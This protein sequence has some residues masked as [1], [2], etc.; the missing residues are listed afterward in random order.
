MIECTYR[1]SSTPPPPPY[2][3]TLQRESLVALNDHPMSLYAVYMHIVF[4]STAV[5]ERY[6]ARVAG[7]AGSNSAGNMDVSLACC[8]V[9]VSATGRSLVQRSPTDCGVCKLM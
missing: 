1:Q 9:E 2:Q 4:S 3:E 5:V 7:I 6:K 8:Q